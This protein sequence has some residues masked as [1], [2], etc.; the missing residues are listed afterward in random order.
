MLQH[1]YETTETMIET[2]DLVKRLAMPFELQLHGLNYLPGT[3]IVDMTIRDGVI[4][5]EEMDKIMYAPMKDQF[6]AYWKR[7]NERESRLWYR[8]TFCLQFKDCR[9][10]C[11]VYEKDVLANEAAIDAMYEK[12]EKRLRTR[13]LYKKGRVVL[14]SLRMRLFR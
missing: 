1:P 10:K 12:C 11:E 3:D 9:K 8:L 14:K 2:Y 4:S 5:A 6:A 13:Y 7:E